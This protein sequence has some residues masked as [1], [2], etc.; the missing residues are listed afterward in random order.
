MVSFFRKNKENQVWVNVSNRTVIRVLALVLLAFI[1]LSVFHKVSH[2]LLLIFTSFFLALALNTPVHWLDQ[3]LPGKKRGSRAIATTISFLLVVAILVA[4]VASIIH[5]LTKD[6]NN[7]IH[8][9]PA[10]V[11][12]TRDK[13]SVVG[14]I[15]TKYK[16][17][18]QIDS[19][20]KQ[21]NDRIHGVTGTAVSTVGKLTSSVFSIIVILVLTFMMLVEGPY[22]L[23][24][25]R[26]LMSPEHRKHVDS[27]A[28]DMYKVIKGYVNGQ[29][30]LA[31][32]AAALI[33]PALFILH[34]SYPLALMVMIFFVALIPLIGHTAGAFIVTVVALF[35]SPWAALIILCYYILYIQIENYVIQPR[36]QATTTNLSP[37]LVVASIV[38]GVSFGGLFGALVAIP[39]MGCLRVAII[40]Y[41]HNR[42]KLETVDSTT[43]P[44]ADTR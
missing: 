4:F 30:L 22:W 21:L 24:G 7:F 20:S 43:E 12:Q 36:I 23:K 41:L 44:R 2:A 39:L 3:R 17:Q 28:A 18:G 25:I 6:T 34:I 38:I 16:L 10:V 15:I 35:H 13:N 31:A 29:V 9:I 40:D 11:H 5:P 19:F 8:N 26:D 32:I 27:L 14:K 42:G 37:L 33:V 1:G